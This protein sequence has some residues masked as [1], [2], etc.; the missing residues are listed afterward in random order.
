[1]R[2]AGCDHGMLKSPDRSQIRL[3]Y[4]YA[5]EGPGPRKAVIFLRA[6]AV[7]KSYDLAWLL[8][9]AEKGPDGR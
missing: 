9:F 5:D 1:M 2:F 4:G 8:I 6:G 3:V 7:V